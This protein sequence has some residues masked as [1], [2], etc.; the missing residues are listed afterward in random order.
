MSVD[1]SR[2]DDSSRRILAVASSIADQQLSR[3]ITWRH[4]LAGAMHQI[5]ALAAKL[6]EIGISSESLLDDQEH[7]GDRELGGPRPEGNKSIPLSV[8]VSSAIADSD[9]TAASFVGNVVKASAEAIIRLTGSRQDFEHV[10]QI[11]GGLDSLQQEEHTGEAD[12]KVV[13]ASPPIGKI[14]AIK[15]SGKPPS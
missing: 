6:R 9:G 1:L 4:I 14:I 13:R 15:P 3:R 7:V 11:S 12:I 10:L 2:L 5:P 8:E